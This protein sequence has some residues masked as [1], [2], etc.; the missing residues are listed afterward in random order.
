MAKNWKQK[1]I[2]LL[3][4]ITEQDCD[5]IVNAANEDLEPGSGV[6][7]A[8]HAAAGPKL[9]RACRRIGGCAAGEAVMTKAYDLP[10]RRVIHT[11]G[12]V[13]SGGI[14]GEEA[15]VLGSC[16]R[17]SLRL[18]S[19]EGLRTIAFPAIS[20]GD[21]GFPPDEAAKVAV[22]ALREALDE[23]PAI[24]EV[25]LVCF[26]IEDQEAIEEALEQEPE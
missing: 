15:E 11:V 20:T 23:F 9:E 5:A 18:A 12:P 3:D 1:V 22:R 24:R 6:C 17:E 2:V 26:T 7:G 19:E 13:Y 14:D 21:Y 10:A 4:D 8:I 25:R 16:Y